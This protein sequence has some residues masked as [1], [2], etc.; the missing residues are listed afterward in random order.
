MAGLELIGMGVLRLRVVV[1]GLMGV[2][3]AIAAG[4]IFDQ[5][6]WE[7]LIAPAAVALVAL[8]LLERNAVARVVGG[9][10]ALV[11]GVAGAALLDGGDGSDVRVAFS[12]GPQRLLSTDW[13]SPIRPDLLATT[14][15]GVGAL[16]W[17]AAELARL[18]RLHLV[19][20]MPMGVAHVLVIAL[21][22]P[23]GVGLHWLVPI[24]LLAAV[25]A[26]FRPELGLGERWTLLAGERR[27]VPLT[28]IAVGL[29][30]AIALPL[31]FA[32]RADPRRNDQP[33]S[34]LTLLDPIEATL[35]LQNIDPPVDLHEIR[36]DGT[37]AAPARWRTAAL[38]AYDGRRW[39]PALTLRPIGRRL[40]PDADD[41]ISG[42]LSFLDDDLQLIP[43]PGGAITVDTAI[44][45]DPDRT[46]VRLADRP[47]AGQEV[48]FS[49]RVEPR[50][51]AVAPGS[52]GTRELDETVSGLTEFAEAII[53]DEA[54]GAPPADVLGR[55]Q[56]IESAMRNDF[57]LDPVASGG[58]LQ[59]T[60]IVRF[61]RDTRRGNSEQFATSFVLLARSLGVDARVAT[62]FEVSPDRVERD[63]NGA[64]IVLS[65]S[66]AAV[67]PEVSV[68][69]EWLAFD[70]VPDEEVSEA[71]EEPPEEQVQT[72]A[73]PQPPIAPPPE[74]TDD[75]VVTEADDIA[76]DDDAL[77]TVVRVGL[78][79]AAV[80]GALL[81]PLLL[82]VA[83]ILGV[84][85]RRRRR[86]LSG[87]PDTRIRGAW[88]VATNQLVDAGMSIGPAATNNE[89]A[90]GGV[91]FA[92]TADRELHRLAVLASAAT[93]GR[94]ARPDLLAEDAN[95]CLG[96]VEHS[97]AA[98]RTR[99]Q[100]IRWRLSLRSLR[101]S[102]RSPV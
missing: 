75:P 67:W 19:P 52:I 23:N 73:A 40:A 43:L 95:A 18:R 69:G 1:L 46:I 86:R 14:A 32:D 102:T 31:A 44:E 45:T 55:L 77:P 26:L 8:A 96:Q 94:P 39:A 11:G 10:V 16:V 9:L 80:V 62:G 68:D 35:A 48:R 85:W 33:E 57:L 27:L 28:A 84:K 30:A 83:L 50:P 64:S 17:V 12:S 72:P 90:D 4:D 78:Q 37:D 2:V 29:A 5:V 24:G 100:R 63:D 53:A 81:V 51:S 99:W 47:T 13:P 59:R 49:A 74:S 76:T 91:E 101:S 36:I 65:S 93:F 6:R 38:V 98:E 58:G 42:T 3:L 60:L 82:L 21:S 7:L 54:D 79:A 61:I 15:M 34:A 25:F 70:P 97:L 87:P 22:A 92:P 20:L 71:T 89:I 66:D 56:L 88:T 41:A